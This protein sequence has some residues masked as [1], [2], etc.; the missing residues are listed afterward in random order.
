VEGEEAQKT[1][2]A[3]AGEDGEGEEPLKTEDLEL[4]QGAMRREPARVDALVH[5]LRLIPRILGAQN[6]RLG[7]PLDPH[8]LADLSQ[9]VFLVVWR[10]LGSYTGRSAFEAWACRICRFELMNVVRRQTRRAMSDLPHDVEEPR[11]GESLEYEEVTRGLATLPEE[12]ASVVE[13]KHY[14]DLTFDEIGERLAISSNTAKTRYYR[15]L[16]RLEAFLSGRVE[17]SRGERP[18]TGE[19]QA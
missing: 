15:G 4:V 7:R 19:G 6:A 13:L 9:D 14:E 8:G 2:T 18:K 12:E 16:T 10:K 1:R 5:R 17:A 11:G 3:G